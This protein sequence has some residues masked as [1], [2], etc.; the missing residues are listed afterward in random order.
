MK[1]EVLLLILIGAASVYNAIEAALSRIADHHRDQTL[2][3]V[4]AFL[5]VWALTWGQPTEAVRD[6]LQRVVKKY[7]EGAA[8]GA[9]RLMDDAKEGE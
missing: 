5:L 3:R 2:Y 6:A 4:D 1:I 9:L 8:E 7:P